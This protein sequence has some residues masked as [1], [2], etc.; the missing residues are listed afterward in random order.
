MNKISLPVAELKSALVG[1]GKVVSRKVGQDI[2]SGVKVERTR[3][4]W[5]T[6][7]GCDQE[8]FVTVRLEQPS[9]GAS[10]SIVIPFED[11]Q[12]T[13]K[14]CGKDDHIELERSTNNRAYI[15]YH[16]GMQLAETA[17]ESLPPEEFP[18][19]PR[20]EGTHIPLP[21]NLRLAIQEGLACS[22][23]DS[24]RP[25]LN[26]LY[27]DV[28][29]PDCHTLVGTDGR[30]MYCSNSFS[31]PLKESLI[32]PRNNFLGWREFSRDGEWKLRVSK[33]EGSPGWLQITSRRWSCISR[34][35]EGTF[36]NW[37]H[38]LPA[39]NDVT[40]TVTISLAATEGVIQLIEKMP[41]TDAANFRIGMELEGGK[42]FLLA[43]AFGDGGTVRVEVPGASAIGENLVVHLNRQ[44]LTKALEFGLNNIEFINSTS[45]LRF[46]S[47][48]RQMVVMPIRTENEPMPVRSPVNVSEPEPK[49]EEPAVKPIEIP[50]PVEPVVVEP[51]APVAQRSPL[52][53]AVAHVES[54]KT[55]LRTAVSQLASVVDSLRTIQREQRVSDREMQNVR[56]TLRS[57]QNV[58]I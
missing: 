34:P 8:N 24:S 53:A 27:I 7:T 3:E 11:L 37:R 9:G 20:L 28:S 5:V 56:A 45:P 26:G 46:V 50:E 42:V 44:M 43:R 35:V 38:V 4:G 48:G 1:L 55:T 2:P 30:H 19:T 52:E 18:A 17:V 16:I 58:R 21:E 25:I 23:S 49:Q 39:A 51:A 31:L 13:V 41:C 47:G 10:T 57:L 40:S 32:I 29:R 15:R 22:S 36:P 54:A 14:V 6:L 33:S 12:R